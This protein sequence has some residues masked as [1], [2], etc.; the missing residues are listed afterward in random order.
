MATDMFFKIGDLDG[1]STDKVHPKEIQVLSF[2]WGMSQQGSTHL[3]TGGGSNKV[4]VSDLTF[5][6]RIDTASTNLI[7]A[8]CSGLHFPTALLTIRKAGGK[9]PVE[10]LKIKLMDLIVSN[11]TNSCSGDG[12]SI[13]ES[14]TLNFGKFSLQYTPQDNVGNPLAVMSS[15]WNIPANT[16]AV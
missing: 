4:N 7:Q 11:F 6:K 1:D 9:A 16:D 3:S 15:S 8:C 5:T 10:Y 2:S 13:Y 14:V 12:D